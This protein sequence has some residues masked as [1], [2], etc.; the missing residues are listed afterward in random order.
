[1]NVACVD[2]DIKRYEAVAAKEQA[3]GAI[4]RT[5][6]PTHK[7]LHPMNMLSLIASLTPFSDQNQSPRN[8]YDEEQRI[9]I[10]IL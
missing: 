7:E 9:H 6:P 8:M 2:E 5:A 10:N 1:M 3:S 4:I